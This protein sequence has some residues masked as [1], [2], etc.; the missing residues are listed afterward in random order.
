M[1]G[2]MSIAIAVAALALA[3]CNAP[4]KNRTTSLLSDANTPVDVQS[5][6]DTPSAPPA[7]PERGPMPPNA[8]AAAPGTNASMAF[9]NENVAKA[10]LPPS[11]GGS[12]ELQ[13]ETVA[14][15]QA[16][17]EAPD[18]AAADAAKRKVREEASSG[19]PARNLSASE[20][21]NGALTM[22][23]SS[24]PMTKAGPADHHSSPA[25]EKDSANQ[26]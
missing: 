11:K 6:P 8:N 26:L 5:P 13:H 20:R 1:Y 22:N 4:D 25:P 18:T 12:A 3:A 9:A 24:R 16:A 15:Q 19:A 14:A 2:S 21:H 10:T 17:A 7:P 23:D